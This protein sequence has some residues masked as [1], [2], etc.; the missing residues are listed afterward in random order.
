MSLSG[1][2]LALVLVS[3]L[4]G[5]AAHQRNGRLRLAYEARKLIDERAELS[6]EINWLN[7]RIGRETNVARL[8]LRAKE[9]GLKLEEWSGRVVLVPRAIPSEVGN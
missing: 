9:L 7:A 1:R 4:G 3:A 2:L 8:T 5:L 6:N